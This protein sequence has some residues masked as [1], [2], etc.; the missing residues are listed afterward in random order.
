MYK[1]FRLSYLVA[2]IVLLFGVSE[3]ALAKS[4]KSGDK[5]T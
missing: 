3:F 4:D 2:A 1:L 5:I